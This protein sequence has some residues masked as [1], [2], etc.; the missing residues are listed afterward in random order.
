MRDSTHIVAGG[1][2]VPRQEMQRRWARR[3]A[4]FTIAWFAVT[5]TAVLHFWMRPSAD[6]WDTWDFLAATGIALQPAWICVSVIVACRESAKEVTVLVPEAN[7]Q[8]R[9]KLY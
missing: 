6:A 9:R 1:G 4:G 7:E 8:D 2:W 5:A 3:C